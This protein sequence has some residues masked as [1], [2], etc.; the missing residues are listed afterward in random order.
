MHFKYQV[1]NKNS[2]ETVLHVL[3]EHFKLSK[4]L[5]RKLKNYGQIMCNNTPVF[6]NYIIKAGDVVEVVIDFDETSE[7]IKPV[8]MKLNILYEDEYIIALDKPAGTITHPTSKTPDTTIA[9]GLVWYYKSKGINTKIRPVSRL[10]K[11]TSGVIVFANNQY[12]Q[13]KLVKQMMNNMYQKEYLGIVHECPNKDEGTIDLP[14]A[15]VDGTNILRK[16]S[17]NGAPCVTH[18]KVL[19][20]YKDSALLNFSLE[21]GRTHQIRVHCQALGHPLVGDTLYSHIKTDLISRQALHSRFVCFIHPVTEKKI[22][23]TSQ[24]PKDMENLREEC[25]KIFISV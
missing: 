23:I 16:I 13:D 8:E 19:E 12:I 20:R 11:D 24:I 14:I 2:G 25:Q 6:T 18:Y 17:E 3:K 4:K 1:D 10:D 22:E 7:N 21:T 15:R 9:N 5:I